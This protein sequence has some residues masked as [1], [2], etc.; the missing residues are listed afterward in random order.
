MTTARI[1]ENNDFLGVDY[2]GQYIIERKRAGQVMN[3]YAKLLIKKFGC[4]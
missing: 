2:T 4:Y 1:N 3:E